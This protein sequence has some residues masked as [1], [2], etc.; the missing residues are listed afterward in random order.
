MAI[1][2]TEKKANAETE[3][4][5]Y[6]VQVIKVSTR[7]GKPDCYKFNCVVNGITIYGM[8]YITYTD[9]AGKQQQF[10]SFPQYKSQNDEKYYNHVYFPIND[11]AYRPVFESIEKQIESLL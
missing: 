6:D 5:V 11:P 10:I 7:K 3:A 8:D 1:N 4:T 9:R 2:R